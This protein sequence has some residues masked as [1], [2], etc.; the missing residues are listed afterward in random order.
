MRLL[1]TCTLAGLVLVGTLLGL[2]YGGKAM[3]K[4]RFMAGSF[5]IQHDFTV[6]GPGGLYGFYDLGQRVSKNDGVG[7]FM[8]VAGREFKLPVGI[9]TALGISALAASFTFSF[10]ALAGRSRSRHN[11]PRA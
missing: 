10:V 1:I 8:V 5:T 11:E 6:N 9:S 4:Y 3:G 2:S 7:S